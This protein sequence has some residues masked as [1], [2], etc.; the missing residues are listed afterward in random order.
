MNHSA[1]GVSAEGRR[2]RHTTPQRPAM[3]RGE[4]DVYRFLVEY[5]QANLGLS[6]SH[7]EIA[8][9]LQRRYRTVTDQLAQLQIKRWTHQ[10]PYIARS[11]VPLVRL[12]DVVVE[13]LQ[14]GAA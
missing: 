10:Q 6:P 7:R 14:D 11:T 3:T 8:A 13:E 1:T 5:R 9:G 4:Y 2:A 12:E